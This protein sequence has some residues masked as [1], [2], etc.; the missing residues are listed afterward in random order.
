MNRYEKYKHSGIE[1]LP[2]IPY[3]WEII[4][5]KYCF[6]YTTGFTPPSGE[7]D[8]YNGELTWI[9]IADMK[10]KVVSESSNTISQ[11]AIE[12]YNPDITKE[13]SLLF[14]F[15]LSVGKVAFAGKDLYTNEAIISILPDKNY[16]VRYFYYTLPE[17]LLQNAN[18][19]I[20]GAQILNQELIKN[21]S[22]C[23]PSIEEQN[24]IVNYLDEK[25]TLIDKLIA[26][27][28][29]LIE[30]L[31]EEQIAVINNAVS[32]EGKN[33]ERKKL[34][35]VVEIKG[36][37]G[38]RGYNVS[39]MVGYGE[40][41]LTIGAKHITKNNELYLDDPEFLSWEKYYES[42]EI[43]VEKGQIL[44]VQRGSL[45]KVALIKEDIGKATIN[46]SILILKNF[47]ISPNYLIYI[48]N[49]YVFKA[50]IELISSGTAVP[51]ISQE[52]LGNLQICIAPVEDQVKIIRYLNCETMRIDAMLGKVEKE[53]SLLQEYRTAL[54]SEVVTGKV[55]VV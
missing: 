48:L 46:P 28:Q 37:I 27:K 5:A 31:K 54:I 26:D 23:F 40:G 12:K 7:E 15:K 49:S 36:R 21:A 43:F 19:N 11:L 3:N 29:K 47:K 17:Q 39:D 42:P 4:K 30:L 32:G 25:T 34:K 9:T 20:Y 52:Q 22:I 35:S 10:D 33:W 45:G 18:K 16:D 50:F 51:M 8:F 38:Y 55:K 2:I 44:V 53:I 14:S 24:S 13:G 1:W 41:A 6:K